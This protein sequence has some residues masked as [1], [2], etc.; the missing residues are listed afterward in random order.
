MK[1]KY[2]FKRELKKLF[3]VLG[4]NTVSYVYNPDNLILEEGAHIHGYH[5][6]LNPQGRVVFKKY[7]GAGAG[8]TVVTTNHMHL[9][10]RYTNSITNLEHINNNL[11]GNID[12][13]IIIEEDVLISSN[14]TLLY[15]TRIGRGAVIGAGSVI[16]SKVPPYA[17]AVGNPAKI[18]GF[19]FTP[20]EIIEHEKLLYEDNARLPIE[21]LEKNY[22]K[23]Y[24]DKREGIAD[25]L[26]L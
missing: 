5:V 3:T 24:L 11:N 16:R 17:I 1:L 6:I 25:Y 8:L 20:Q 19:K 15:G 21:K 22:K 14:V 23:Y 4:L 18:V 10:G 2:I 12:K 9:V 26:S 13:D 7:S